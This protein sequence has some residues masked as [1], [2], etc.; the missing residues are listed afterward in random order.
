LWSVYSVTKGGTLAL[1]E[2]QEHPS[3][4]SISISEVAVF[5]SGN[6]ATKVTW[7]SR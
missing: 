3:S 4:E 1:T 2:S 7:F 6:V 5:R